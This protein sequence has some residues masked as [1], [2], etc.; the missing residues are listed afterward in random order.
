VTQERKLR[1]WGAGGERGTGSGK[2][3]EDKKE[4]EKSKIKKKKSYV[5]QARHV[6]N[7]FKTGGK[8]SRK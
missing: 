8:R 4:K 1:E 6:E 3:K 2:A 7:S 5:L